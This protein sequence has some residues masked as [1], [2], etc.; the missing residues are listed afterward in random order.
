MSDGYVLRGRVWP[1]SQSDPPGA[2][3]YLHG[4][5]SHG[6]W[7]EW[8]AS[9]LAQHGSMVI[10]PDRRGSGLNDVARGDTP[11]A[12]R[13]LADIDEL[14]DWARMEFGV[15]RFDLV[16]V[17]WGGKLALAWAL[18]RADRTRRTLL[19]AP[20]LYPAVDVGWWVRARIGLSL[21]VRG[22]QTYPIPLDDPALFTDNPERRT[23]IANDPLKLTRATA[24]FFWNSRRLDRR[25]LRASRGELRAET[26]LLLAG[27]DAI[28]KNRPTAAWVERATNGRARVITIADSAHTLEFSEDPARLGAIMASWV[29]NKLQAPA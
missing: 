17:S 20:G 15:E 13:W 24:R 29:S 23:F 26:T 9:L 1:P 28:I 21:L 5:Q 12:E 6:G 19:V 3:I 7:F 22:G 10:L 2:V 27:R 11:S 8:S 14:A 18:R 4:I 25:L 16:G